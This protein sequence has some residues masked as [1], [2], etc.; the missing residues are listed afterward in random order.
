MSSFNSE[1][2]PNNVSLNA[3]LDKCDLQ[4]KK[5]KNSSRTSKFLSAN[6]RT[7]DICSLFDV[8]DASSAITE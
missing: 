4:C 6:L 2:T 3:F 8:S 1:I 5:H 7:S